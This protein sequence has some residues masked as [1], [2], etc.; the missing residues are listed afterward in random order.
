MRS[1]ASYMTALSS[2]CTDTT[3]RMQIFA[4]LIVPYNKTRSTRAFFFIVCFIGRQIIILVV[5]WRGRAHMHGTKQMR[6][7]KSN[8]NPR[9][10]QIL[11]THSDASDQSMKSR[12]QAA[13]RTIWRVT[14]ADMNDVALKQQQKSIQYFYLL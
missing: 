4:H 2:L 7:T 14:V 6:K 11:C 9:S 3:H 8:I 1:V 5:I 12:R 10:M 13:C